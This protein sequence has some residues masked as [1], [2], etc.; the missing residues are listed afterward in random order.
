MSL[1]RVVSNDLKNKMQIL[2]IFESTEKIQSSMRNAVIDFSKMT[3][4]IVALVTD[5]VRNGE[6]V[7]GYGFGSNGR[8]AQGGILRERLIPRIL[9]TPPKELLDDRGILDPLKIQTTML[10]NEKPGGHGDRAVAA[11]VI[12][13][14]VWDAVAKIE[15]KPLWKLLSDKFNNGKFDEEVLVY[16]GGGYYYDGREI[17]GLCEEMQRY[18]DLG[19]RI[20]KMKIGGT[21]LSKDMARI[22]A[23]LKILGDKGENL[24]VD[25]NGKFGL[26][27]ALEYAKEIEPLG[28]AWYEEPG[29]PLDYELHRELTS[30]YDGAIAIGENSLSHQDVVNFALYGGLRPNSDWIQM[31]PALGYGLTEYLH[32]INILKPLGW[33]KKRHVPHGGHQLGLNMAAGLQLGGTESYPLVFKPFGGFADNVLIENGLTKVP[34]V[35]GIGIELKSEIFSLF[36]RL[37]RG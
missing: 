12:D 34:E 3:T 14:A 27:E 8:Y 1:K 26:S 37:T 6:T 33:A 35:P 5:Q 31:D 17:D 24:A 9:E 11:A 22:E 32:T 36:S 23:V 15:E 2:N 18:L 7:I 19:Y 29:D 13:M 16:P 30:Q 20:L 25:A 28:L 10:A 4:S 21:S